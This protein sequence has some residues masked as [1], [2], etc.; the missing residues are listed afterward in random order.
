MTIQRLKKFFRHAGEYCDYWDEK[1]AL[2]VLQN[3]FGNAMS[4]PAG[5]ESKAT[6]PPAPGCLSWLFFWRKR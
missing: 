6:E 4:D 1:A 5:F 2:A 3:A